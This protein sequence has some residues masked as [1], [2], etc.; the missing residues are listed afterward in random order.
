MSW[1]S[2]NNPAGTGAQFPDSL[3]IGASS[4]PEA[5]LGIWSTAV[6]EKGVVWGP[7]KDTIIPEISG[8]E[9]ERVGVIITIIRI[10]LLL[11][12]LNN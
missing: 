3:A 1:S 7:F 8:Y 2:Q 9:R 6:I 5:G 10:I 4:I 12:F 11:T